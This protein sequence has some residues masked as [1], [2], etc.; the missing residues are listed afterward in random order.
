AQ[1]GGNRHR[2]PRLRPS[3]AGAHGRAGRRLDHPRPGQPCGDGHA[4]Q[5][6]RRD[7]RARGTRSSAHSTEAV[8]VPSVGPVAAAT[9]CR[10]AAEPAAKPMHTVPAFR[11][12]SPVGGHALPVS[13]GSAAWSQP[14]W[15]CASGTVS[16]YP[17]SKPIRIL[18]RSG[19]DRPSR[20]CTLVPI[21]PPNQDR[22]QPC[23][24]ASIRFHITLI[25]GAPA[26]R[27]H[28]LCSGSSD[29]RHFL[30]RCLITPLTDAA[31]YVL[32]H[33]R[34][35]LGKQKISSRQ[36]L[37]ES[38]V[39]TKPAARRSDLSLAGLV[40]LASRRPRH[41]VDGVCPIR[42]SATP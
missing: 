17:W 9:G 14:I 33:G 32:S 26:N 34:L 37:S 39:Q 38:R 11:G 22:E 31:G 13:P 27:L 28:I 10:K 12:H 6:C 2:G 7:D 5:R 19:R 30:V 35:M 20:R 29:S 4:T 25:D 40:L 16:R 8:T 15:C 42:S 21:T 18:G 23:T 36:W 3:D 1:L 24:A 41:P